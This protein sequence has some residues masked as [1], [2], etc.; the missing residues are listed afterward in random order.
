[1][2][3]R[4]I[5]VKMYLCFLLASVL[6]IAMQ[7][8]LD[9]LAETGPFQDRG[10][11]PSIHD[12]NSVGLPAVEKY[13]AG[14]H[15]GLSEDMAR[16]NR[17]HGISLLIVDDKGRELSGLDLPPRASSLAEKAR[18]SGVPQELPGPPGFL[19]A[20]PV[21]GSDKKSYVVISETHGPAF[22]PRHRH[23]EP[24]PPDE[25][26]PPERFPFELELRL[27]VLLM[28]SG[29]VCYIFARYLTSP[30]VSLR[31]A[32]RRF[33]SGD[34]KARVGNNAGGRKDEISELA[35]DFDMMAGRIESL[36]TSQRQLLGDIS[37][38]LRTPLTRLNLAL[39]LARS[40]AGPEAEKALNRVEQESENL[41][42]LIGELLTFAR[43]EVSL[44]KQSMTRFDIAGLVEEIVSDA[45]FEAGHS[46]RSVKLEAAGEYYVTG[47]RE[48]LRRAIENVVRNAIRY[49]PED[50]CVSV[51]VRR[52]G[53]AGNFID[54]SVRD[55]GPGVPASELANIFSPFYRI[56]NARERKTGGVGLGLAITDRAVRLHGGTAVAGNAEGGGLVVTLALPS[57][58]PG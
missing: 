40:N 50:S 1:M 17:E 18:D 36:M 38:E 49:T 25:F 32:T 21:T 54:I 52:S 33:A 43:M 47:N 9:R 45:D 30:L 22:G 15:K 23:G 29:I 58:G 2:K 53:Q 44:D 41:N 14:D 26:G 7:L 27:L 51:S 37:H 35:N 11:R 12:L 13:I 57:G 4:S 48:L 10:G 19:S 56:S 42:E 24:G 8:V 5:F 34:L 16:A 3:V 39:E 28:V 46:G 31:E 6:V 20:A 55:S